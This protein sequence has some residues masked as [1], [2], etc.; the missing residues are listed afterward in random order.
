MFSKHDHA[1]DQRV[2]LDDGD[3]Q[4]RLGI[5]DADDPT[6]YA[7]SMKRLGIGHRVL[8]LVGF[9]LP[10]WAIG[11]SWVSPS[12]EVTLSANGQYRVTVVPRPLGGP[13][14]Y[15]EDKVEG[16]EPAGQREGETQ[17][18]P[19]AS[20]EAREAG[21]EWRLVWQM[22]LVNDVAPVNVLLA[23]NASFLVTFDNWH[24]VGYGD[25][26][27]V[28]YDREGHPAHTYSLEQI[29]PAAYVHHLPRSV[30]SRWWGGKHAL[31]EG[32]RYVELRVARPAERFG[33]EEDYVPVRIRLADGEVLLPDGEAWDQAIATANTLEEER[34]AA[35]QALRELR[36]TPLVPPDAADTRSWRRYMLELRERLPT[37]AGRMGGMV[38]AAPGEE[39]G[40]DDADDI[41]GWIEDYDEKEPWRGKDLILVSPDAERLTAL[42]AESLLARADGSMAGAHVVFVGTPAEGQQVIEAAK[43]S[44][45]RISIVD[46]TAAF[47][48]GEPLPATPPPLWR[49]MPARF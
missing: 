35:W 26:V 3:R 5:V 1:T 42:L 23:D 45:A 4:A 24:S 8:V 13:L 19:M 40:F 16:T 47:P 28:I 33:R 7:W 27:V 34:I 36:A 46:R 17:L 9:L 41:T 32:D 15:F 12:T 43:A 49:P 14:A 11:D 2:G 31:V 22:P 48:P 29:L 21:D 25:D 30:S 39:P 10:G 37:E 38:L 20:V 6:R 44:G 18:S